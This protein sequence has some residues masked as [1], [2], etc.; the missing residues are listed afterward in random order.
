[1]HIR[2]RHP[3]IDLVRY[4]EQSTAIVGEQEA[5]NESLG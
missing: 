3:T 1:M 4:D 2:W 5:V